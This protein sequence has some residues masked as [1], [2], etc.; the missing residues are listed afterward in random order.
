MA[1]ITVEE[2]RN[3][4]KYYIDE[5]HQRRAVE[6]LYQHVSLAGID[7]EAAWIK[8]YRTPIVETPV[9]PVEPEAVEPEVVEQPADE[10]VEPTINPIEGETLLKVPYQSQLDNAS[11]T[12][13]RECFSSSCA[14]IAMYYGKV[15][16]DDAYNL[17]RQ[18]YGD[19]TDAGA[20]VQAL[21]ELG[22]EA[23]FMTTGT[24][25]DIRR[26]L[27]EGRPV[28]VGWLHKGH[29]S[30]PSGGGH[31]SVV[32]GYKIGQ[33]IMHDPNGEASLVS[34][35][36]TDNKDGSY[37]KY[38]YKNW[39]PRWI[40]GGEGDGWYL[41]VRDPSVKKRPAKQPTR[42]AKPSRNKQKISK[43][44]FNL[45]KSFEGCRLKAYMCP[46]GVWTIGYGHTKDVKPGD[47]ITP[48]K[49]D[50][51]LKQDLKR[52]EDAVTHL[53]NVP[54]T[55]HEF[56]A[57]VSFT[58]NVG[59]SA[60]ENSTFRRRINNGEDKPLCFKEEFPKWVNGPI[61]ALAGLVRRRAAE[62]ELATTA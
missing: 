13:Y 51:L 28:A 36:Y 53:I 60:L 44:G 56:D 17:V 12:G 11:G 52:Y 1:Q 14:M 58:F 42:P 61:G 39:N 55:Q 40:V 27:D 48:A 29:V 23:R 30:Q 33:W 8:T 59:P 50:Q 24:T 18:N 21:R 3:F 5:E 25:D 20:Q 32:V 38:S 7:A 6:Q 16:N 34:G 15:E 57:T 9:I 46:S 37:Q 49:A 41:D 19:S 35:G 26:I 45:I 62:V 31:W 47:V 22:L 43:D 4:F 2:F 10:I 54:F